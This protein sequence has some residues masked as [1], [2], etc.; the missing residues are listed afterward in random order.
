M[1]SLALAENLPRYVAA[2]TADDFERERLEL[3]A[4]LMNPM[5]A[6]RLE[7]IGVGPGWRCLEV[8]AG[9]G[10]VARLLAERVGPSGRVVA[11]DLNPRFLGELR[12]CEVEVRRHDILH[13]DLESDHYDLVHCRAVLMHLADPERALARMAAALRPGGWLFI[14]EG[15][16]GPFTAANLAHPAALWF[17]QI[18]GSARETVRALGLV[19]CYFGRRCD[20]LLERLGLVELEGETTTWLCRGG[21]LGARFQQMN[22]ELMSGLLGSALLPEAEN[23]ALQRLYDDPSFAFVHMAMVGAWG[24]RARTP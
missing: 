17:N 1:R 23:Q 10:S 8:G 6:S 15:D 20:G 21:G 19:D 13:D 7:R 14:E 11:T 22:L 12:P 3:L 9:N 18:H 24:R 4:R 16:L 5:T 2:D